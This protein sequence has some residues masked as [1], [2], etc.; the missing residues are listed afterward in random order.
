MKVTCTASSSRPESNPSAVTRSATRS[1][2]VVP[3]SRFPLIYVFCPFSGTYGK[4]KYGIHQLI[5]QEVAI[6][7]V[8]KIHAPT[9]IR[10]IETWRRLKHPYI[11]QLYEVVTS[12][13]KIYMVTEFAAGGELFDYIT[14]HGPLDELEARRLFRQLLLAMKY[15]HDKF[16]V[17]R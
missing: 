15:C 17:H 16:F 14:R 11:A 4:V 7:I 13:S 10:E 8:D 9:V 1:A 6:K 5:G 2:K 3:D 12:E